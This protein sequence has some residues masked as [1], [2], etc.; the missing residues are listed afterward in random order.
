MTEYPDLKAVKQ[1][2]L[3]EIELRFGKNWL[4]DFVG[5]DDPRHVRWIHDRSTGKTLL[6]VSGTT[7]F[8]FMNDGKFASY[9]LTSPTT[10][11]HIIGD[12]DHV[13]YR[14]I[15]LTDDEIHEWAQSIKRA[16]SRLA[17]TDSRIQRAAPNLN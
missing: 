8:G 10:A 16:R 12:A 14:D 4:R 1:A 13:H 11:R 5:D 3:E 9:Q 15:D 7:T 6:E 17:A 2:I